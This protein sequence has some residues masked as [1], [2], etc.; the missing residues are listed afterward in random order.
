MRLNLSEG[1]YYHI[2]TRGVR[3]S[4]LFHD[5]RDY[6]RFLYLILHF[7]GDHTLYNVGK[8]VTAYL[9]TGKFPHG[10]DTIRKITSSRLVELSVFFIIPNHLHLLLLQKEENGISKY[11]QKVLA[12]YAKYYNEKYKVTGHLFEGKFR[13]VLVENNDQLLH[14]SAYIHKN[15]REI[16][17]NEGKY[18]WSSLMDYVGEPRFGALLSKDIIA[19]QFN[20]AEE[21]E[22]F[23]RTSS[24]KE[25][26]LD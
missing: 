6:V 11:M 23:V 25:H 13:R 14:L 9:K 15:P 22:D 7:Q 12:A 19:G 20:V 26:L 3:K 24:A 17:N 5:R 1:E 10:E 18:E 8:T 2:V 4:A 21:Y 16:A